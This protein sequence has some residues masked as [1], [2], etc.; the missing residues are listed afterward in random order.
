M[1]IPSPIKRKYTY[2]TVYIQYRVIDYVH[3]NTALS[4][5]ITSSALLW[6]CSIN[7]WDT[8]RP[9]IPLAAFH[10]HRNLTTAI[11]WTGDPNILISVGKVTYITNVKQ[12]PS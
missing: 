2:S 6:D 5:G 10:E 4:I 7:V 8:R 11:A 3:T 9:Y 12:T 1:Y